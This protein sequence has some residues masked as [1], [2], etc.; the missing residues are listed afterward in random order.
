MDGKLTIEEVITETI[1][2]L[3]CVTIPGGLTVEAAAAITRPVTDAIQNLNMCTNA[4]QRDR[5]AAE[6]APAVQPE[7]I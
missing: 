6:A 7:E 1:K 3:R 4:I 2:I 5:E